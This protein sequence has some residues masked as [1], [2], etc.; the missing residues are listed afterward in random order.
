MNQPSDVVA[1]EAK[2]SAVI[3]LISAVIILISLSILAA[4]SPG[5]IVQL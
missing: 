4:S 3:I 2:I 5:Y 1:V